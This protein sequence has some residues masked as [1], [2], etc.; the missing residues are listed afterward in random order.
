LDDGSKRALGDGG[1]FR[2]GAEGLEGRLPRLAP[3]RLA[4]HQHPVG[5]AVVERDG[6]GQD[7]VL[8]HF[9]REQTLNRDELAAVGTNPILRI[10]RLLVPQSH[11]RQIAP[12]RGQAQPRQFRRPALAPLAVFGLLLLDPPALERRLRDLAQHL[13]DDLPRRAVALDQRVHHPA[14]LVQR[15]VDRG[16]RRAAPEPL[17]RVAGLAGPGP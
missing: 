8:F 15:D 9:A 4:H 16:V 5:K 14:Q 12:V 10:P 7:M 17:G 2:A 13:D 6:E 1:P 3:V 11:E